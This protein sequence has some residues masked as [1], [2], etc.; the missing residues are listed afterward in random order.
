MH[1]AC[2]TPHTRDSTQLHS[3]T[4]PRSHITEQRSVSQTTNITNSTRQGHQ[5]PTSDFRPTAK[6]TRSPIPIHARQ[7]ANG[8]T[9]ALAVPLTHSR[10]AE[11]VAP[12]RHL[13]PA[14]LT[15]N[16]FRVPYQTKRVE[17][18]MFQQSRQITVTYFSELL[19]L[20]CLTSAQAC[21]RTSDAKREKSRTLGPAVGQD[22]LGCICCM[23]ICS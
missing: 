18:A 8:Q 12:R 17:H 10:S 5:H 3:S 14:R 20:G 16:G 4:S 6:K 15:R 22:F 11:Q 21:Q 9:H 1:S 2:N 7:S 23:E 19:T 13:L